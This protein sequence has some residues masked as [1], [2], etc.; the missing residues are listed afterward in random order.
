MLSLP[1]EEFNEMYGAVEQKIE[2]QVNKS[3]LDNKGGGHQFDVKLRSGSDSDESEEKRS[4]VSYSHS[5]AS[6]Y[7][8]ERK[9]SSIVSSLAIKSS[10]RGGAPRFLIDM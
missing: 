2:S 1:E 3:Y 8:N 5:K 4:F 10:K 6:E 9:E 7:R